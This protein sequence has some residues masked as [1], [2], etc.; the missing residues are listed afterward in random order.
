MAAIAAINARQN[1][2]FVSTAVVLTASDT[3]TYDARFKQLLVVNNPTAGSLTLKIDGDLGTT[4]TKPGV[5]VITVSAGFDIVI[6][7]GQSRSVELSKISD[8]C[9]ATNNAVTLTGAALCTAQL[10]NL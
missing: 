9:K 6:P 2:A 5:G 7:A 4:V 8:Y 1:G 10:F 3:I